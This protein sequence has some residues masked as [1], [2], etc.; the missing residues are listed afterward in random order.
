MKPIA[1]CLFVTLIF[2]AALPFTADAFK[3]KESAGDGYT[4]AFF[5][6]KVIANWGEGYSHRTEALA[7]EG[8]VDMV[9]DDMLLGIRYA[10]LKTGNTPDTILLQDAVDGQDIDVWRQTSLL[11][12]YSPDWNRVKAIGSRLPVDLAILVRIREDRE[13][14]VVVYLYDYRAEKIYSKSNNGV[15]YGSMATGVQ[16]ISEALMQDFYNSQ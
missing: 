2:A 4:L 5:P 1:L 3:Q 13:S 14:L 16:K 10:F 11:A 12:N 6:I 9:A 15:Y 7:F 8:I